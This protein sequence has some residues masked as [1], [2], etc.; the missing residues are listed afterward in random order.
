MFNVCYNIAPFSDEEGEKP[1]SVR[2]PI[3][4]DE[5]E[6]GSIPDPVEVEEM[7]VEGEVKESVE[8]G[9]ESEV[10]VLVV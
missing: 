4:I 3:E 1:G 10:W 5:G 6:K 2:D 9:A 8:D 7:V